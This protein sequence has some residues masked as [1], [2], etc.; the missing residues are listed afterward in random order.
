MKD[1]NG[2][3]RLEDYRPTAY[4]IPFVDLVFDLGTE[5][6]RVVAK[7][8]VDRQEGTP[9]GT[10]LV[11]DG[12]E[13]ALLRVGLDDRTLGADAFSASPSALKIFSPPSDR[14]CLEIVTRLDPG[15]NTQLMGLYKSAGTYCT[16]CE[17]EGFRRITYFLDRPDVMS[18][19]STRIE[20]DKA[21][22]P[23]LL[24]N[25]NPV[26]AGEL[27]PSDDGAN[28]HYAVWHDPHPKPA[29]LFALVAGDLA[30]VTDTFV[31]ASGRAID[32]RIYVE[33]GNERR[34][35]YAMN[36]LKRS[37]RWDEDVFGRE[38]D[39]DIFMIV[40]VSDFNMG[41]MENKGLNIFND[42]YV[43]ADPDT[44]TDQDY[45]G[46]EG[47]IA[48]EYF[49]NWTGNR[50][51]CRDWFQLCLKEGL[52]VFRDQ[53]FSADMR[54]RPVKRIA[55][56][57]L[58]R[59]HQFPED[60]GPLAHPVRPRAYRQINN[61]YTATVYE[62]GAEIVRMLKIVLG[63]EG[64]R[65]GMDLYFE[66]HDGDAA[67]IEDFLSCFADATGAD[68]GRFALWYEQAGTPIVTTESSWN[69]EDSSLT[70]SLSQSVPPT[71]EQ[72]SK[73]PMVIPLRFGLV[74]PDG[75]D[76]SYVCSNEAVRGDVIFLTEE[77]QSVRFENL[78]A[79]PKL[80]LLRGFSAPVRLGDTLSTDD[81]LFLF[82][83]DKDAFNRWQAA[84]NL[85]T[86]HLVASSA[87]S[88]AG[89]GLPPLLSAFGDVIA[90]RDIDAAFKAL[91]LSLPGDADIVQEIGSDVDPDRISEAKHDLRKAIAEAHGYAIHE[92]YARLKSRDPYSADAAS[93]GNRAL[94]N[95]LLSYLS[96]TSD[97]VDGGELVTA[98]FQSAD[99][100][101][102]RL[103]AF[104]LLV[105]DAH[106][107]AASAVD[108][109]YERHKSNSLALD[110]WF[111]V[112]ATAPGERTLETVQRLSVHEDFTLS[113]PNRIR[114]LI[115]S[116]ASGNLTGFNRRDGAGYEFVADCV[117]KLNATN[118]QVAARLLTS[119]NSWRV[120]EAG[121]RKHA[122]AALERIAA[123]ENLSS[124]VADI[125][126][127]SL[128]E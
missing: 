8:T 21:E 30:R 14:F 63:D 1:T 26:E 93:A 27:P 108:A 58:L 107:H 22:T 2:L 89:D 69:E 43:L 90:N 119:F 32:L 104:S 118:A 4:S 64:F 114:A 109:F 46:I 94:R 75:R 39:L 127:R 36:A 76:L 122:R 112:Q 15:K 51:T 65:K 73:Q 88:D 121:R 103:V 125:V 120:L 18:V 41:A 123:A 11:L 25:G 50:I 91:V 6:T 47:V 98:Q 111:A 113:N 24:A 128:Q 12:D 66:R 57:R 74:G 99:N 80:S 59:S 10:P 83:K 117:L 37:M 105:H 116:F 95:A 16:Q 55:D 54:S 28:R 84:Q 52:T 86:A 17:A 45:A 13:L 34:C 9:V 79:K 56:V 68:L 110:K 85:L 44:A 78:S 49:H 33:H 67:T 42:K 35:G 92:E 48:H 5:E 31:T 60:A 97:G 71:P 82:S 100:M 20:A 19:Y 115:G 29:Y 62:K 126:D 61:F 23:I 53:E 87:G 96:L 7:L 102:D 72:P 106:T 70:L 77:E 101:T 81:K 38:Y 124:D 40:A 3:V